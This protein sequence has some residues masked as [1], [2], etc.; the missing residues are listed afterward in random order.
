MSDPEPA[1]MRLK[2][3]K[4]KTIQIDPQYLK[5]DGLA[6]KHTD[7]PTESEIKDAKDCLSSGK[8]FRSC[9]ENGFSGQVSTHCSEFDMR[10]SIHLKPFKAMQQY[11]KRKNIKS[12]V[13]DCIAAM[14]DNPACY[15]L[16]FGDDYFWS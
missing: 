14:P 5:R 2:L 9:H 15:Q 10:E 1:K 12:S 7:E 8:S 4:I 16:V 13:R 6:K 11:L 3:K